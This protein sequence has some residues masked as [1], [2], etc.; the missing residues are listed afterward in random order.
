MR[1][2]GVGVTVLY[3]GRR[4]KGNEVRRKRK[5]LPRGLDDVCHGTKRG[6]VHQKQHTQQEKP[7]ERLSLR[8]GGGGGGRGEGGRGGL[9]SMLRGIHT[10]ICMHAQGLLSFLAACGGAGGERV[11]S[12]TFANCDKVN[13]NSLDPPHHRYIY[14]IFIYI[15]RVGEG[16]YIT[17]QV[18]YTDR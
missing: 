2:G 18:I 4:R 14:N 9:Y 11:L 12:S 15:Q 6:D 8:F 16:F 1:R 5:R 10:F 17:N 7:P 13:E 3:T